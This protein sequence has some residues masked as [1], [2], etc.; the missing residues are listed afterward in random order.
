MGMIK[1]FFDGLMATVSG[2]PMVHA[3]MERDGFDSIIT[4]T[5]K[6][7]D[8]SKYRGDCTVWHKMPHMSRC[9]TALEGQLSELQKYCKKWKGPW[10]VAHLGAPYI[11]PANESSDR[12]G[13][14]MTQMKIKSI[15][16]KLGHDNHKGSI[17]EGLQLTEDLL[18]RQLY[19]QGKLKQEL[20]NLHAENAEV[21]GRIARFRP[22][23]MEV[24]LINA[25]IKL[26]C[27]TGFGP[28]E[29]IQMLNAKGDVAF[30]YIKI[31]HRL[32]NVG[33]LRPYVPRTIIQ[34]MFSD[35]F[36]ITFTDDWFDK[37]AVSEKSI[38]I[39]F[40]SHWKQ[41]Q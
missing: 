19:R 3:E 21:E 40:N 8:K 37:I 26:D 5:R 33:V 31:C 1:R 20:E 12:T 36:A 25:A 13:L 32:I 6:S 11:E 27:K 9:S 22:N 18:D 7:G 17:L 29:L 10:P 14:G 41:Q 2:D 15:L 34:D 16:G 23:D 35:P 38:T 30:A 4:V 28:L 39:K 24:D